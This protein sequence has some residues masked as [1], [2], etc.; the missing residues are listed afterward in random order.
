MN[1]NSLMTL[2]GSGEVD[3]SSTLAGHLMN[4]MAD[5]VGPDGTE[6]VL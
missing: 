2:A 4:R 1:L 6:M 3:K 5:L